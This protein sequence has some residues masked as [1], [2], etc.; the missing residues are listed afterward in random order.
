[1][2]KTIVVLIHGI[3]TKQ[4]ESDDWEPHLGTW[5]KEHYP[6][7][8]CLIFK[9]GWLDPLRSWLSTVVDL[10]KLPD[11]INNL[12]IIRFTKRLRQLQGSNPNADIH[13]VAHS[14]GTWVTWR[15]LMQDSKI[16]L[17]SLTL[18]AGVIS[19]HI[20]KNNIDRLLINGQIKTVFSWSSHT[21]EV[22]RYIAVPPF[23]HL[24]WWGFLRKDHP[25]DRG[26]PVYKPYD[27]LELYNHAT[28]YEHNDYFV[29]STFEQIAKDII[30]TGT[31]K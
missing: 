31:L 22:V 17:Q 30:Y 8:E 24:G 27:C 23:G 1:M 6:D 29:E 26:T 12:A 21:D 28:N 20:E 4:N 18:I 5:I 7:V 11:W 16:R 3:L 9:Y 10:L 14:Y 15:T 13:V 2:A 25:E 19:A